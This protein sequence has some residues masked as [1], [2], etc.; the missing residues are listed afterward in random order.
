MSKDGTI[1]QEISRKMTCIVCPTGCQ[2]EV[3]TGADG[4]VRIT[5]SHCRRGEE[6]GKNEIL[7]PIRVLTTTVRIKGGSLPLLPVRSA[8]AIPKEL[9]DKAMAVLANVEIQAP[10]HTGDVVVADLLGTDID[11]IASRDMELSS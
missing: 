10:V 4:A 6:Y 1:V 11:V 8:T 5:G 9:L 7:N 3:S 2:L